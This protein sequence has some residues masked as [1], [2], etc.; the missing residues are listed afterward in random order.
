MPT[1]NDVEVL[2]KLEKLGFTRAASELKLL[3]VKK[4]KLAIAYE[5]YR[6]VRPEKIEA[7]NA[8]LKAETKTGKEPFSAEWKTLEFTPVYNYESV[9]PD[10][11]MAAL[12]T[13]QDYKC[14]DAYEIASIKKVK[15]PILFGRINDCPDRFFI[16][17]WDN[18]VKIEDILMPNE[19]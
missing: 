19:G 12:E 4:R 9:P 11:A 10:D 5:H 15:D 13:A 2:S 14:F 7:F 3:A 18:D 1:R 6:F 16:A 8:K 17:Q